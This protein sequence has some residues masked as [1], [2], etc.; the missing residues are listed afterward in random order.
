M[1]VPSHADQVYGCLG[2][3]FES[4]APHRDTTAQT[5][6]LNE[7]L[8]RRLRLQITSFTQDGSSRTKMHLLHFSIVEG[9]GDVS[10]IF[11]L[12]SMVQT[13]TDRCRH[14]P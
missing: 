10:S 5:R 1:G 13:Q 6:A 3:G 7:S 14:T 11:F 12:Q 8:L 9:S 2:W 4:A